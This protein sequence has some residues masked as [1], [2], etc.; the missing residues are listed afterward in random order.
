M[1][2]YRIFLPVF[3]SRSSTSTS[4][5]VTSEL[6][7]S[8]IIIFLDSAISYPGGAAISYTSTSNPTG[9]PFII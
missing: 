8:F 9:I 5:S 4:M 2:L 7:D 3:A 6:P 1:I